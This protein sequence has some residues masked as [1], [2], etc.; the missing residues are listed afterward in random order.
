MSTEQQQYERVK[1]MLQ[2]LISPQN[3][4]TDKEVESFIK[5]VLNAHNKDL[6]EIYSLVLADLKQQFHSEKKQLE[7]YRDRAEK[8]NTQLQQL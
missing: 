4:V 8:I 1:G 6:E 7:N 2:K 5:Q 3:Q